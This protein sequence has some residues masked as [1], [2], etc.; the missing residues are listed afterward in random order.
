VHERQRKARSSSL[1]DQTHLPKGISKFF[2]K[3]VLEQAPIQEEKEDAQ[4]I[5]SLEDEVLF[6]P[7]GSIEQQRSCRSY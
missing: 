1:L 5:D 3:P 6:I 2:C 4:M 7:W